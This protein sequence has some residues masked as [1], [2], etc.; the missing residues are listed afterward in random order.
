VPL[1]LAWSCCLVEWY[2]PH[3]LQ[4]SISIEKG[5]QIVRG[6]FQRSRSIEDGCRYFARSVEDMF[7]AFLCLRAYWPDWMSIQIWTRYESGL[8][9]KDQRRW[10]SGVCWATHTWWPMGDHHS[11]M[12]HQSWQLPEGTGA[13][14]SQW[15]CR[16]NRP[17]ARYK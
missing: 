8:R 5:E 14:I 7:E 17:P 15:Q 10:L 6:E 16:S 9:Y 12:A 11:H 1:R 2:T 4:W 3:Y 13:Q